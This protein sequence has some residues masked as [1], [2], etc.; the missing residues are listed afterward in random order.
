MTI[1]EDELRDALA[2]LARQRPT[3]AEISAVLAA[4]PSQRTAWATGRRRRLIAAGA[5]IGGV[6]AVVSIGLPGANRDRSA[7]PPTPGVA[8]LQ[9]AAA[10]AADQPPAPA[11]EGYR[12]TETLDHMRWMP[13]V[14]E[15]Q[16]VIGAEEVEQRVERW[17]DGNWRGRR[18]AHR[19]RVIEGTARTKRDFSVESSDMPYIYGDVPPPDVARLPTDP[20]KLREALLRVPREAPVAPGAATPTPKPSRPPAVSG[21]ATPAPAHPIREQFNFVYDV[22]LLLDSANTT[23]NQRAGLWGALALTPGVEAAPDVHDSLG[24]DGQAVTIPARPDGGGGTFTIVFDPRT[25]E[26]LSWSLLGA[27]TGTPDQTHTILRAAHVTAIGK[28]PTEGKP[29]KE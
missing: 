13:Q 23:P 4:A 14:I 22:L 1:T 26:L 8:L 20:A 9:T 25:S 7:T 16:Q 12:Y 18:V 2:P 3:D 6:F 19:G 10:V 29:T 11:L 24:R 15:G 5:V 27:G 28:R 17:V 21:S